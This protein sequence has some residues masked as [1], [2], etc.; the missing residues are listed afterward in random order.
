MWELNPET[1]GSSKIRTDT[2]KNQN[3]LNLIFLEKVS[4]PPRFEL[5]SQEPESCMLPLHHRAVRSFL[6]CYLSSSCWTWPEWVMGLQLRPCFHHHHNFLLTSILW[7]LLGNSFFFGDGCFLGEG[8]LFRFKIQG[9]DECIAESICGC[10]TWSSQ[11]R[12]SDHLL[13]LFPGPPATTL[14]PRICSSTWQALALPTLS[15]VWHLLPQALCWLT[16]KKIGI[17]LMTRVLKEEERAGNIERNPKTRRDLS[18]CYCC[19]PLVPSLVLIL[20][21]SWRKRWKCLNF[22]LSWGLFEA[23]FWVRRRRGWI[24]GGRRGGLLRVWR[25]GGWTVQRL[26]LSCKECL[27]SG[28]FSS[29]SLA[30]L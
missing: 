12:I 10:A 13:S 5:G 14:L 20:S 2:E 1:A 26:N 18:G 28:H 6:P 22:A 23:W 4:A 29:S 19:C 8:N 30:E 24:G 15:A 3:Q 11:N 25:E 7:N 17:L 27:L 9:K 16:L 21:L